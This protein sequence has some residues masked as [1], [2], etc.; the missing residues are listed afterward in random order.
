MPAQRLEVGSPR[1]WLA[2]ACASHVARGLAGGF[3]Q[4]CHGKCAPLKRMVA[5]DRV[6]YYSPGQEMGGPAN[7]RAFTALGQVLPVDPYQ[8]DMSDL[9]P[10]FHPY[11][12]DVRWASQGRQ[13]AIQSLRGQLE[14]TA[15][16]GWGA[17]LRFG[18]LQISAAD[19]DCIAAALAVGA[20]PPV[21]PMPAAQG[22]QGVLWAA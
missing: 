8:V 20:L 21:E 17:K 5:G 2:V 10:G 3:M 14:L 4:V 7:L 18:L 13:V 15:T 12:R 6:V 11:R 16:P 22:V 19:M 9:H 1:N